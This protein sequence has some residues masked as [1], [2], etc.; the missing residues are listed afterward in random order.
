MEEGSGSGWGTSDA[1]DDVRSC[2]V[3]A[4]CENTHGGYRCVC[5]EGLVGT[6]YSCKGTVYLISDASF[7]PYKGNDTVVH[8]SVRYRSVKIKLG[9]T[10]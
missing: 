3:N 6:G 1:E 4:T 10:Q 2:D 7:C 5:H 9:L 8:I